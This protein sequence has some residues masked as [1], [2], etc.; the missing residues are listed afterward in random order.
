M[1]YDIDENKFI[2]DS[3]PFDMLPMSVFQISETAG[4]LS[5]EYA[6][7]HRGVLWSAIR[8]F[9]NI[10]AHDHGVINALW[11]WSTIQCDIPELQGFLEKELA[12]SSSST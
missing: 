4:A 6:E 3:A 10:I 5:A 2:E 9:C 1:N 11:A 8:G 12:Q 7:L